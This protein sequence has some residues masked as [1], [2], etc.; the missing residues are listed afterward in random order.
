LQLLLC[1]LCVLPVLVDGCGHKD[2]SAAG[3]SITFTHVPPSDPGGPQRMD[4]IEGKAQVSAPGQQVVLYAHS[5]VWWVQPFANNPFSQVQTD[6]TWKNTTH[7]GTEYAALLVNPG[8]NPPARLQNIPPVGG[9][10]AAV[11]VSSPGPQ[12]KVT[13]KTIQFSGY[14]W[15]VRTAGSDRG[16]AP[17]F[18]DSDNAWTD[19]KGFLHLKMV[20]RDG[21]WHCAEV[22]LKRNLGY[23][24]YRFVVEDMSRIGNAAAVELFTFND[25]SI[26][27]TR[28]ELDVDLSRWGNPD[29]ENTQYVV[30][31]YFVPQ[32]EFRFNAPPGTLT[33]SF[34]W[35]SDSA[36]FKTTRGA[37]GETVSQHTFTSGIPSATGQTA[38]ID[39]FDYH[40]SKNSVHE[41]A[42]VVIEKFEYLP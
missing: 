16:G 42:E 38:H 8:Y 34:R 23:G 14:D 9:G 3:A 7:L 25:D 10:V 1:G 19:A 15:T 39:L 2:K 32:N 11:A 18:Y 20:Q 37:G 22:A 35:Q 40:Y 31:P 13:T 27:A 26:D 28:N 17:R 21:E 5:G 12:A 36:A 33:Y 29:R 24:T 41:P 30:Q 4:Y 6:S